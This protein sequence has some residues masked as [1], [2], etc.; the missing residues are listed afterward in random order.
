V[1]V[2]LDIVPAADDGA[3]A[4][5]H[6]LRVEVEDDGATDMVLEAVGLVVPIL[7]KKRGA[8]PPGSTEGIGILQSVWGRE[9]GSE[10]T[11]MG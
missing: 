10:R 8:L 11:A 4:A 7:E 1:A 6:V 5:D 9:S 2:H 3:V